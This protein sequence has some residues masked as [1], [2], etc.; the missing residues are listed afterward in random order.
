[1]KKT[2]EI[3]KV[4]IVDEGRKI[5]HIF[6][7]EDWDATIHTGYIMDSGHVLCKACSYVAQQDVGL[8]IVG[9]SSKN[10]KVTCENR[11]CPQINGGE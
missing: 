5:Y 9:L 3:S 8:K 6:E 4:A 1:M 2:K 11:K 10:E 7:I